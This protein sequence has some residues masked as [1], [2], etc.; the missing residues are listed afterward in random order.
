G[1]PEAAA[2]VRREAAAVLQRDH[3][4]LLQGL[5][6]G[7]RRIRVEKSEVQEGLRLLEEIPQRAEPVVCR[8]LK[9]LRQLHDRCR[10]PDP[11]RRV[12]ER[13]RKPEFPASWEPRARRGFLFPA[14]LT[15]PLF[16][17]RCRFL[18][19]AAQCALESFF[20]LFLLG[21]LV[22]RLIGSARFPR[23]LPP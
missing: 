20:R 10:T 9:P 4:R 18:G 14:S 1:C 2:R 16:L 5:S 13:L 22:A 19:A 7:V 3:G 21:V 12:E 23:R 15:P 8:R 17:F 11:A 6:R